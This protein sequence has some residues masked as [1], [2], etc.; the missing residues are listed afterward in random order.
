MLQFA[1]GGGTILK[2]MEFQLWYSFQDSQTYYFLERY[3]ATVPNKK[4]NI[5]IN[6]HPRTIP[7]R[8]ASIC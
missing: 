1:E 3:L 4:N 8:Y 6:I 7:A 5:M 2:Y